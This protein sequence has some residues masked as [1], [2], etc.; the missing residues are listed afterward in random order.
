VNAS[1]KESRKALESDPG[2]EDVRRELQR[3]SEQKAMV[4]EMATRSLQ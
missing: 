1:I 3:A 2:D 4:Y